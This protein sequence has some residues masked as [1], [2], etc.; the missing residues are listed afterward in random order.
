MTY[1]VHYGTLRTGSDI[2]VLPASSC[3]FGDE[4]RG[5]G[6]FS[7]AVAAGQC[8]DGALLQ[9]TRGAL[10]FWAVEW[11]GDFGR[12][13]VAAGPIFPRTATDDGLTFGGGNLTSM[14]AHRLLIDPAW[15]DAQISATWLAWYNL[16]LGSI[17]AAIVA[18]V[19]STP[20]GDLPIV[21]EAS[22]AGI[23][24]RTYYGY[25]MA[26]AAARI[27]E[28]ANVDGGPDYLFMPR[29]KGGNTTGVDFTHLEWVLTTGTDAA[30]TLTQSGPPLV[31]DAGAP[32]QQT[33]GAVTIAEDA[34]NLATHAFNAGGGTEVAK[35]VAS[36]V[37]TLRTNLGYP[38]LDVVGTSNALDRPT[39]AAYARGLLSRTK[40]TPSAVT[41]VVRASW[42]WAQ[43]AQVGTTVRLLIPRHPVFGPVDLTSRVLK[44]GGDIDS[45]W[46]TLTLADSLTEI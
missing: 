24:T 26:Y 14:L 29:F 19:C 21:Y 35:V 46:V 16:D 36:A 20:P 12:R 22:R 30:P 37:D 7:A 41:V 5:L 44:W 45:E 32:N 8:G 43:G 11:A 3:T 17:M 10:T 38:R 1:I 4:L 28:L 13:I 33:I 42:W 18:R 15:S 27:T 2:S 25:D 6:S 39:V 23:N 9:A 40:Q 34:A 31:L